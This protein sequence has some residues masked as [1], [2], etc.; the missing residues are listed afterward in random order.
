[1]GPLIVQLFGIFAPIAAQMIQ[2][3][4]TTHPGE[5]PTTEQL[6]AEFNANIDTYLAEGAAWT[7][8][9]PPSTP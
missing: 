8:A 6:L 4:Q 7:A 9:H 3:Y 5:I 1:M 2:R